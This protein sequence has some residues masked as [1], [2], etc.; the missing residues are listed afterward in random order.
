[1][2]IRTGGVLALLLLGA[3]AAPLAGTGR[4][5]GSTA[6]GPEAA[7]TFVQRG[8][9]QSFSEAPFQRG[10]MAVVAREGGVGV[11]SFSLVPCQEGRTVCAGS[12]AGAAGTLALTPDW[13]VVRGLYGRT[14]WLSYGGDGFVER[15]GAFWPLSWNARVD[16]RGEGPGARVADGSGL[17]TAIA[18]ESGAPHR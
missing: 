9:E 7:A 14:F 18:L 17:S 16:G 2:M 8:V 13:T 5:A 10:A 12:E 4:M 6:A 11:E 3:C 15:A 1:M